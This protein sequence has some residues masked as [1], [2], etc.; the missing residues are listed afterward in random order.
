MSTR[1]GPGPSTSLLL[2]AVLVCAAFLRFAGLARE[3]P[4]RMEPDAFLVYELQAREGDPA[5]A[6][7]G[8][9]SDRYPS[10]IPRALALLPTPTIPAQ[11]D[12]P[13]DERAHLRAAARPFVL[14]RAL[15]ALAS[16]A[17]VAGTWFLARRF[18]SA[19]AAL[20]ATFLAATSVLALLFSG[21]ARPHAIQAA[22][23]LA[24]VLAALRVRERPSFAR[25]A[26]AGVCATAAAATLQNGLFA[27]LPLAAGIALADGTGKKHRFVVAA[28]A[29]IAAVAVALFLFYPALPSIDA[30]GI[31][32]GSTD[33]GAHS[34]HP[35][36]L[37]G[38]PVLVRLLWEHDP[39][40]AILALAGGILG[41][42]RL[43]S[44]SREGA[45]ALDLAVVLAYAVPYAG[46]LALDPGVLDRFLLPLIPFLACLAAGAVA[47]TLERI[48][49]EPSR[50]PRVALAIL[51]GSACFLP[52]LWVAARFARLAAG[53]DTLER[54][55][56][57]ICD[58][59]D[60][61]TRILTTPLTTLPLLVDAE[62]LR[63]DLEDPTE[64]AIPWMAYQRLLPERLEGDVRWRIRIIPVAKRFDPHGMTSERA[65]R[66]IDE[67]G[68][69]YVLLEDLRA[70][71]TEFGLDAF[72][73]A[74]Q[75]RGDLA[76]E[77]PGDLPAPEDV[78]P[79]EYQGARRLWVR[80][81][82]A[83]AFGPGVRIYR[84]R[85]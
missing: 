62:D 70:L 77:I 9:F 57:W 84:V 43:R 59:V 47:W 71:R 26:L 4:H 39:P 22:F 1:R 45:R 34:I 60:P 56:D 42:L 14:V 72:E 66:W 82:G 50:G 5:F 17:S 54:T 85:R 64:H 10:L 8:K 12:G 67:T 27:A 28:G 38:L 51:V 44:V 58:H 15:V 21:Q 74:A 76:F 41:L 20:A 13:G 79:V 46:A 75:E 11:A 29:P 36:L 30:Q 81:L 55:A 78:G 31:H 33:A 40:L 52:P 63:A 6:A 16:L 19:S 65:D 53:E 23:A 3:L 61:S 25:I 24:T 83:R 48:A 69:G 35:S 7:L 68:A 32:L 80:L 37:G 73:R 49:G 2:A 18:L